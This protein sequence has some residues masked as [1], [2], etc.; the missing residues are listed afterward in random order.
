MGIEKIIKEA[1]VLDTI[2]LNGEEYLYTNKV[3]DNPVIRYS[4]NE[5]AKKIH[6]IDFEVWYQ[7]NFWEDKYIPNV[8]I[9]KGIVVANASVNIMHVNYRGEKKLFIQIGTVMTDERYRKKGLSR[10]LIEKILDDWSGK[11]DAVYLYANDTVLD[12]YPRFG[13]VKKQEFQAT[14]AVVSKKTEIRKLDM[15]SASDRNLLYKKY[16]LLNPFSYLTVENNSGLLMFYCSQFMKENV[17][18]IPKYDLAAVVEYDSDNMICYDVFGKSEVDLQEILSV[19]ANK[20]TQAA[21][22][23]F[24]PKDKDKFS[25]KK[26]N[27]EDTTLFWLS[28]KENIFCD[29]TKIMFQLLSHA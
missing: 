18:Y 29:N 26:A 19:L 4:F 23:G 28:D 24:T 8:L 6:G 12:F 7:N 11:C 10:W 9:N 5:L 3:K 20:N 16:A 13:F 15:D 21:M 1:P 14:A 2:L 25:Y 22:L 17:Y 27:K